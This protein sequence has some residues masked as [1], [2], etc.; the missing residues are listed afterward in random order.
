MLLL[1]SMLACE[2][3]ELDRCYDNLETVD[4]DL[5]SCEQV[6]ETCDEA[7]EQYGTFSPSECYTYCVNMYEVLAESV[8]IPRSEWDTADCSFAEESLRSNLG[9]AGAQN[10]D[11]ATSYSQAC[12][13][14]GGFLAGVAW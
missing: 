3:Q 9:P 6:V 5:A 2:D 11:D 1:I 12:S 4:Q 13:A 10:I 7:L 8:G 14:W